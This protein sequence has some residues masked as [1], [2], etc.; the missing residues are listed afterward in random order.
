MGRLIL[1]AALTACQSESNEPTTAEG[2][3]TPPFEA[4]PYVAPETDPIEPGMT[5]AD[6][7][8]ALVD[9]IDAALGLSVAPVVDSYRAAMSYA[10]ESCPVWYD[11]GYGGYYWYS[12]CTTGQGAS[13][14]GYAFETSYDGQT[15]KYG[16]VSSGAS[17]SAAATVVSPGGT[18]D[19]SG[20]VGGYEMDTYYGSHARSLYVSGNFSWTGTEAS[21]TWMTDGVRPEVGVYSDTMHG[22]G[23]FSIYGSIAGLGASIDVVAFDSVVLYTQSYGALCGQEPIGMISIRG[24]DGNWYD[25]MF[26]NDYHKVDPADCDGCG[27]VWFRGEYLGEACADFGPWV[28]PS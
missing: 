27:A 5:L 24:A 12:Y 4:S 19:A 26:D 22:A 2:D 7:E 17:I 3:T 13:Y 10:D 9:A 18:L 16:N 1:A 14:S 11:D 6:V 21:D 25:V 28:E 15:D 20:A 23:Y 8:V